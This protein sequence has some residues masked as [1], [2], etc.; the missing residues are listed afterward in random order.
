M[1]RIVISGLVLLVW[2]YAAKSQDPARSDATGDWIFVKAI[3]S[4]FSP[5]EDLRSLGESL[6]VP[7]KSIIDDV[8][9]AT[10]RSYRTPAGLL[11]LFPLTIFDWRLAHTLVSVVGLLAVLW[12][13]LVL[14]PKYCETPI[15]NLLLPL[16]LACVS[17]AFIEATFWGTVSSIVAALV[18]VTILHSRRAIVGLPL[19]I[20]TAMKLYP[21]ILFVPLLVKREGRPALFGGAAFVLA[22]MAAGVWAFG[23]SPTATARLMVAGSGPWLEYGANISLAA[24][25]VRWSAP[26]WAFPVAVMAGVVLVAIYSRTRPL[27][28]GLALAVAVSVIV[29]PVS[30]VSYDMILIPLVVW[31]WTKPGHALAKYASGSWLIVEALA[32]FVAEWGAS[33]L[34]RGG[35]F[36]VRV[37]IAFAIAT[38]PAALWEPPP[39]ILVAQPSS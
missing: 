2:W 18:L 28:Q 15:E 24:F 37:L 32:S 14:I 25:L 36:A 12:M 13:F 29:S 26:A 5:F 7:Y 9:T 21:G 39:Q 11:I 38:A 8:T 16:A 20:A 22:S 6:G 27:E 3:S 35:I 23:L 19:A 30:W 33:D 10:V 1:V 34:A 4:G 31:L 17:A